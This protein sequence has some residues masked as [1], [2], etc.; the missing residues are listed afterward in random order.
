MNCLKCGRD[1]EDGQLF[2]SGCLDVMRKYPVKANTAV[3]LPHR[4]ENAISRKPSA[5]RRQA[6]TTEEKFQTAKRF[7]HRILILWLITLG[8]LIASLYPAVQFLL[9]ETFQLP[10]QNYSTFSTVP[11]DPSAVTEYTTPTTIP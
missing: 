8:L 5:K 7:L 3:Q 11:T 1:V 2:C 10:G 6:P 4:D 9:G